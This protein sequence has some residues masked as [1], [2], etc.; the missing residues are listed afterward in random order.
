MF[1]LKIKLEDDQVLAG[2]G[3]FRI[4][5]YTVFIDVRKTPGN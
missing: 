1:S 2:I 5:N 4:W 3:L